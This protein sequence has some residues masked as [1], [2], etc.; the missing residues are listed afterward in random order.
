MRPECP[1]LS[2]IR[3]SYQDWNATV[4]HLYDI[5]SPKRMCKKYFT[6]IILSKF[7]FGTVRKMTERMLYHAILSLVNLLSIENGLIIGHWLYLW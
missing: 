5:T 4:L 6:C 3:N 7:D 2:L 1:K